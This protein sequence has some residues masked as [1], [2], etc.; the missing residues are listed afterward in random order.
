M[1]NIAITETSRNHVIAVP[2]TGVAHVLWRCD[3]SRV[4]ASHT[5]ERQVPGPDRTKGD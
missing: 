3:L 4:R 2:L 1:E 5:S